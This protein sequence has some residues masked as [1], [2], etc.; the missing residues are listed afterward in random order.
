MGTP[1]P[2]EW[3]ELEDDKFYC[4]TVDLYGTG[5]KN[6]VCDGEYFGRTKCSLE[7]EYVKYWID[8]GFECRDFEGIC[9][10]VPLSAQRLICVSGPFDTFDDCW[11]SCEGLNG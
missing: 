1:V 6:D 2:E 3:P 10:R 4:C 11:D 5:G 8:S 9:V 7:G